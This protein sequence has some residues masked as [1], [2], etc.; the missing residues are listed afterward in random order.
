MNATNSG[1]G[2]IS[3]FNHWTIAIAMIGM[4][5]VGLF[6]QFG[7]LE[8]E[9]A[10]GLRD[11]HKAV[12]V[13]LMVIIL[14]R[15]L[16]RLYHGF[17]SPASVMSAWQTMVSKMVHWA[18]L[19]GMLLMPV[20][21]VI[22]SVYRGRAVDV[23]GW[24]TIPAQTEIEAIASMASQVHTVVGRVLAVLILV[25]ILAALKH[26]LIDRDRTLIRMVSSE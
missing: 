14:W 15:V 25:H 11:I 22:S 5:T 3:R 20:S 2:V 17:P 16:W 18:L 23:F 8:R 21:G 6:L 12:G 26:H 13:L 4:T 24:F 9:A 10:G 1:Y 7:G 19:A